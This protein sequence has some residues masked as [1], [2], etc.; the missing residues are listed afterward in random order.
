MEPLAEKSTN[1]RQVVVF[2]M[3]KVESGV[4]FRFVLVL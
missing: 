3:W 4:V 1:S 2:G